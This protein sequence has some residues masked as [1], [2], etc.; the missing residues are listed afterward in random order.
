MPVCV[1][2]PIVTQFDTRPTVPRGSSLEDRVQQQLGQSPYLGVRH[3]NAEIRQ[4]VLIL[5]GS[6]ASFFL[7][8][9]AQ[10]AVVTVEGVESIINRI[11]VIEPAY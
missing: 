4:G 6:V 8:Q 11:D 3:V 10:T 1:V 9:M 5:S 7:K 2:P